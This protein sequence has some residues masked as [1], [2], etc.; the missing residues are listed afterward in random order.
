[1]ELE[2]MKQMWQQYD[3]KLQDTS[4]LNEKIITEMVKNRSGNE[5]GKML[6][7]EYLTAAV[8]AILIV[9]Y[10][11]MGRATANNSAVMLCYCFSLL[12]IITGLFY[13][14]YKIRRLSAMDF[15]VRSV[16]VTQEELE[17]FRILVVKERLWGTILLPFLLFA[18]Y[19][20]VNFWVHDVS[21]FDNIQA[22]TWRIGIAVAVGVGATLYVYRRLYFDTI[23]R[24][25]HN[26]EEIREF[27]R[28]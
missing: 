1:M 12:F 20:V 16:T 3:K 5:V 6:N 26:L 7:W 14:L 8:Y 2:E 10:V 25:K 11:A 21:M 28:S 4:R 13:T 15:G 17:A 23:A 19:V 9:V 22:Y 27:G 24:L 18:I